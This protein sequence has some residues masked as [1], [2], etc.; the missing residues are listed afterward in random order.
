MAIA[1]TNTRILVTIPK[2]VKKQV[3]GLAAKQSSS[4]SGVCGKIL[5]EY[6]AEGKDGE[7]AT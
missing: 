7:R 4:V 2:T 3:D 6:F 1:K 5:S